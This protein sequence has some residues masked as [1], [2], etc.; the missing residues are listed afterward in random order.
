LQFETQQ[1]GF[2]HDPVRRRGGTAVGRDV[3]HPPTVTRGAAPGGAGRA[4][5]D[6]VERVS[7]D[8]AD[9]ALQVA[10]RGADAV[11]PIPDAVRELFATAR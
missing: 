7:G 1:C 6:F 10:I 4:D 3:R 9:L 8:V 11:A 2:T 5:Q